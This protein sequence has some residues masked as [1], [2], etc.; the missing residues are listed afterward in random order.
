MKKHLST[1]LILMMFLVGL[2]VLLYPAISAYVNSRNASRMVYDYKR[3]IRNSSQEVLDN[4]YSEAQ[5]YNERLAQDPSA[6]YIP[7]RVDG[8]WDALDIIGNGVMGSIVIDK[9]HVELPIYHGTDKGVLQVGAGHLE[10]TSLPVG[11]EGTH[12]VISGHR[13]LPSARLFTDLDQLEIGDT[14]R[15]ETLD[16]TL[17]YSVDQVLVVLPT[18]SSALMPIPGEDHCTLVTCTPYGINSHRLLVRGIRTEEGSKPVAVKPSKTV[19]TVETI[20]YKG[21][22]I[23]GDALRID[24]MIVAPFVAAPMLLLL[25]VVTI[26]Q[27]VRETRRIRRTRTDENSQ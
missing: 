10:G 19:R 11:G 22:T 6:F 14:F 16:R 27:N 2:S 3:A 20:T 15:L 13:G 8:Y 1:I 12:C 18:D 25:L 4:I 9:I 17:T 21:V 5:A 23:R 26:I 24:P 7:E